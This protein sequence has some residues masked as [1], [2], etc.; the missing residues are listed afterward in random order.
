MINGILGKKIGMTQIFKETGEVIP[1]TAI[2][3]GPCFVLQVKTVKSDGYNA[4]Q[5]GFGTKRET[6]VNKADMG[7]FKK[8]KLKQPVRFVKE[9]RADSVEDIK[10]SDNITLD[11]FTAGDYVDI[12]GTS[13]GKGFQGG[14]K[15]WHWEGG[16]KTHGS[17]SHRRPGSIGSSTSPSRV[18]KGHHLPG[19]MGNKRVTVQNVEVVDI[20]KENNIMLVKGAVCGAKGNYLII[21]KALKK[22]KR[23]EQKPQAPAPET[24]DKKFKVEKKPKV[25]KKKS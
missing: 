12:I 15:R 6:I 22:K 19:H 25:E 10:L 21:K 23:K 5:L 8:A 7:R 20:D 17:M 4:V 18:F 16:P 14:V 11:I 9:I 13:I 2:E 1:V 3:A 24:K